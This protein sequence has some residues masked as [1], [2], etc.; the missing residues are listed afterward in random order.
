MYRT[1]MSMSVQ[2]TTKAVTGEPSATT[3]SEVSRAPV[4]LDSP[5]MDSHVTV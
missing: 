1:Q 4:S 2:L 5:E 3:P